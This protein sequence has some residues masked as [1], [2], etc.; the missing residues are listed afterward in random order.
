MNLEERLKTYAPLLKTY[1]FPLLAALFALMFFGYGLI[2]LLASFSSSED[3]VF[4]ASETQPPSQT[5]SSITVDIGGAVINPGV[6]TLPQSSR[7]HDALVAAGGMASSA[8]REWVSKNLNLASPLSDG[9]KLYIPFQEENTRSVQGASITASNH[10]NIN[11]ASASELEALPRI[12]RVTAQKIIDNRPYA[13]IDELLQ[14]KVIG[15]SVFEQIK[16][17]ISVY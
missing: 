1:R 12:G 9:S 6:Y 14:K 5:E 13:S 3:I 8:H 2:S 10:I 17:S 7:V 16:D 15:Q 4:D 11:T